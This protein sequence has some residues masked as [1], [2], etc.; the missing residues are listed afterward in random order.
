MGLRI[1]HRLERHIKS[2]SHC[3]SAFSPPFL[4]HAHC[5]FGTS[6]AKFVIVQYFYD[7]VS[8]FIRRGSSGLPN[9]KRQG[10]NPKCHSHQLPIYYAIAFL[11]WVITCCHRFTLWT[12]FLKSAKNFIWNSSDWQEWAWNQLDVLLEL[13]SIHQ[14]APGVKSP[15]FLWMRFLSSECLNRRLQCTLITNQDNGGVAVSAETFA[16]NFDILLQHMWRE[17]RARLGAPRSWF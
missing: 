3:F 1:K 16:S 2:L 11:N 10:L 5:P 13:I 15:W 7:L 4:P 14:Q 6:P 12:L 9:E 17:W 8:K